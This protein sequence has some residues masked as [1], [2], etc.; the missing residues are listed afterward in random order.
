MAGSSDG[1]GTGDPRLVRV[2]A[3]DWP[4]GSTR[5]VY[6]NTETY[7]RYVGTAR[8]AKTYH[9][10]SS[11]QSETQPIGHIAQVAHTYAYL[12]SDD[13]V[14]NE[15]GVGIVES[16]CSARISAWPRASPHAK[17]GEGALFSVDSLSRIALERCTTARCAVKLMGQLAETHGF[18]GVDGPS[19]GSLP[20]DEGGESLGVGDA[21]EAWVF[22]ILPSNARGDSA[23]WVAQRVPDD[24]ATAV[25]NMFTI[26]EV[27][28]SDSERFLGSANLHSVAQSLGW[29]HPRD[30]PLDF[31]RVYSNGEYAHKYYSGRR[32]WRALS[33]FAPSLGLSPAYKTRLALKAAWPWSVTPDAL[34]DLEHIKRTFRDF[35]EGTPFDQTK[36]LAAGP[37]GNPVR[38]EGGAPPTG[39]FERPIA[40]FRTQLSYI[41]QLRSPSRTQI[42]KEV[43]PRIWFGAHAATGTVYFPTHASHAVPHA[44]QD[45]ADP[46]VLDRTSLF[47]AH[48]YVS[49]LMQIKWSSFF[50]V[51]AREQTLE[52]TRVL[53]ACNASEQDFAE[54]KATLDEV[55]ARADRL[56]AQLVKS[57][58]ALSDAL[59]TRFADGYDIV[60]ASSPV[61]GGG[62]GYPDWWLEKVGYKGKGDGPWVPAKANDVHDGPLGHDLAG[63]RPV[64]PNSTSSWASAAHYGLCSASPRAFASIFG[65]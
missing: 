35:Y 36:G 8:G 13:G 11:D 33:L 12:E 22:H 18:Y 2:P 59:M 20:Q 24:Q 65:C 32:V 47:W 44:L 50:P 48:R 21:D 34:V 23:V 62:A 38:W 60:P 58:W 16:S 9:S 19:G 26:R 49:N 41:L 37:F 64:L 42:P 52:E 55:A 39:G 6:P 15:H 43:A 53:E 54:G 31:T 27:D 63:L 29:W 61:H 5:P 30:G 14:L 46:S 57:W 25:A 17:K 51:V 45:A 56:A 28:L 1:D 3:R 4:E 10:K 7:P 40:I